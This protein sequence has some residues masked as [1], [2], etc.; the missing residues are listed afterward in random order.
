MLSQATKTDPRLTSDAMHDHPVEDDA[1]RPASTKL[2]GAKPARAL[3]KLPRREGTEDYTK[4]AA[5]E[6]RRAVEKACGVE[7]AGALV[8]AVVK[9][10]GSYSVDP[11]L[12]QGNVEMF[13]GCAQVPLGLAGPMWVKGESMAEGGE[14]VYVPMATTEGTLVA[15]FNRGMRLTREAGG[16][17]T[18]LL[19]DQMQ[20]T[21][22][23]LFKSAREGKAFGAWVESN[24]DR[25]K[26]KAEE[27]TRSGKLKKVEQYAAGKLRWLRFC[28]STGDAAGQNMVSKATHHACMWVLEQGPEGLEHFTLAANMDTDKKHSHLNVLSPRGKKVIAECTIPA[29]LF[30]KIMHTD[31]ATMFRQRQ[32]SNMGTLYSAATANGTHIANGIT[33]LFIACG[34]DVANVAESH[35]GH[36]YSEIMEDGSYY[37]SVTIPALI[38][39]THGGGTLLP[40]QRESL[41]VLGCAGSGKAVQLAEIAAAVALCGELSL[42]SAVVSD[43]W[44]SSHDEYGRNRAK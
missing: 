17:T 19:E 5:D 18:T 33:A 31:P 10:I 43:E 38:V 36:T 12:T 40:T 37:F 2:E 26:A 35:A 29:D 42:G 28:F 9:H 14:M 25:I 27:T 1:S 15:S 8:A 32:L 3:D 41:S 24:F 4:E 16:I 23:F 6:R 34:Q 21:P 11:K 7:L 13:A 44:V 20:R 39:A 30:R 22:C